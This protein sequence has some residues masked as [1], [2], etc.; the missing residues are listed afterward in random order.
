MQEPPYSDRETSLEDGQ[1]GQACE[2]PERPNVIA[3]GGL[4]PS[5]GAGL[6]R[7]LLTAAALGARAVLV[8]TAWTCQDERGVKGVEPRSPGMVR[9]GIEHALETCPLGRTAVKVGMAANRSIVAA[10]VSGLQAWQ[11]PVVLDPVRGA[12]GGGS[13]FEGNPADLL[14]LMR[15]ATIVTP[16][17]AEAAWLTGLPVQTLDQSR[18]AAQ[19]L[20]RWS[21]AAVLVK[22]GHLAGPATDVLCSSAGERLYVGPR[23]PGRS[24]RGTGCALATALAVGLVSGQSLEQAVQDAKAWLA[25]RIRTAVPIGAARY[26]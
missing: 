6:V 3:V 4:D 2:R 14:P 26:L 1:Y 19:T 24:P 5:G 8:G 16:N 21:E 9:A 11:G 15:R 25:A 23:L 22:G 10:I 18:Q 7:D 20:A 17:L 13:L 12:S